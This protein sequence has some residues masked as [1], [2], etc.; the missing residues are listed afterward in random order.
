MEVARPGSDQVKSGFYG[1]SY[2]VTPWRPPMLDVLYI[3]LT[4]LV[5]AVL[6]LIIKGVEHF[7]R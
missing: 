3:G 5:F 6:F 2:R 7:E 4:I 1:S